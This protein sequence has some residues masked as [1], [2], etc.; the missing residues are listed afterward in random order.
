MRLDPLVVLL[1]KDLKLDK[2]FYFISGN[3]P[4]LIQKICRKIIDVYRKE[5]NLLL[6]SIDTINEYKGG[7]GLFEDKKIYL[8]KSVN[9]FDERLLSSQDWDLWIKIM[10]KTNNIVLRLL[11]S[12]CVTKG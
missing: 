8:I 11:S 10:E 4:T 2:N 12:K 3:E 9:G 6:E 7:A 1:N 5:E